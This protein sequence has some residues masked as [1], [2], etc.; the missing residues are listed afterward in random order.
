MNTPHIACSSC[1]SDIPAHAEFCPSC[2]FELARKTL[3]E[4]TPFNPEAL[5]LIPAESAQE[6]LHDELHVVEWRPKGRRN[7]T[8]A[9]L[10]LSVLALGAGLYLF[11]SF[12]AEVDER[13]ANEVLL[14]EAAEAEVQSVEPA[15]RISL[16]QS[17]EG[18]DVLLG[19]EVIL[20][21]SGPDGRY[22]TTELRAESIDVRLRH[23]RERIVDEKE[24]ARFQ[25]RMSATVYEVIWAGNDGRSL[26]VMD[27]T[28]EDVKAMGGNSQDLVANLVADRLT[29]AFERLVAG[30]PEHPSS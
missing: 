10:L 2:G 1:H 28:D 11:T 24:P 18:F 16:A 6:Q 22:E 4:K 29:D 8:L 20:S 7:A 15:Q 30:R 21:V 19:E 17:E 12:G 27:I 13:A 5:R 3:V 9:V 14:T 26:R 25:A 23:I